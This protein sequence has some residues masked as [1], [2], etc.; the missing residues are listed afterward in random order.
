MP[1]R[2]ILHIGLRNQA[3]ARGGARAGRGERRAIEKIRREATTKRLKRD[4]LRKQK[5]TAVTAARARFGN[6]W[7]K[8]SAQITA[9]FNLVFQL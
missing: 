6:L 4:E 9:K 1:R 3:P 8:N 7:A 5:K 2:N